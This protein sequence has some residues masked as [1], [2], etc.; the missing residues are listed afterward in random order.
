MKL[1]LFVSTILFSVLLSCNALKTAVYD[2]YSYQ[3]TV[4]LKIESEALIKNATNS[5]TTYKTEVDDLILD[6][7][8]LVEYEKNKP[9]NQITYAMLKIMADQDKNLLAGFLKR[10]E[11]ENTLSQAFTDEASAQIT[12][13]FD[14]ILKY[15]GN[16]NKDNKQSILDYLGN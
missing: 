6:L 12:E 15:E 10:W 1:K 7:K 8:K 3:Q 11:E 2:Q 5:F 16:K 13:A 14:L 4:S 9:N